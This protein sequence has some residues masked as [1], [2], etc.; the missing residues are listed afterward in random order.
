MITIAKNAAF[1]SENHDTGAMPD[2]PQQ[3]VHR[4]VDR[5]EQEQ[6]DHRPGRVRDHGR[7]ERDVRAAPRAPHPRVNS[8]ASPVATARRSGTAI[9]TNSA[10]RHSTPAKS[11]SPPALR[12]SRAPRSATASA[13]RRRSAPGRTSPPRARRTAAAPRARRR[14]HQR[15]L[16]ALAHERARSNLRTRSGGT[17]ADARP[18]PAARRPRAPA[19]RSRGEDASSRS[20]PARSANSKT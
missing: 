10:D 1:P 11:S 6:P 2:Q 17:V 16:P 4:A 20:A 15:D 19:R 7:Q 8:S 13:G 14:E 18:A 5:V 9:S 3:P 12:S